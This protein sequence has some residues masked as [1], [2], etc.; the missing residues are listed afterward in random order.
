MLTPHDSSPGTPAEPGRSPTEALLREACDEIEQRIR[1]GEA[2]RAEEYLAR[3]PSLADDPEQ[4]L[5]LIYVEYAA[6]RDR[7][8]MQSREEYFARFPH[9]QLQLQRQFHLDELLDDPTPLQEE[10]DAESDKSYS[11]QAGPSGGRFRILRL[12]AR[13]GIGQVMRAVDTELNRE[14]A[15]KELQPALADSDEVRERF[16]REA[17]ITGKLEHPGIVPVYGLGRD[18]AG[19]P[20]YAMRLV[21]GQSFQQAVQTFHQGG[22]KLDRF[23]GVEFQKLL[24]RFLHVCETVAFAHSRGIIH[25]DLKPANILLGPFGETLVVDWGLARATGP[26][27]PQNAKPDVAAAATDK[28][29]LSQSTEPLSTPV[30]HWSNELTQVS[31]ELIGTP[32]FM[33]PEQ[34]SG[35]ARG[36][37]PAGDVY[38]LG[39]TLYMLLTGR[40]PFVGSD[41]GETLVRVSTGTF[42]RPRE[43]SRAI[44]RALEAVCLKAMARRPADRY[45]SPRALADDLEHWLADEP[46]TAASDPPVA[47]LARWGRRHRT[48]VVAGSLALVLV[49]VVAVASAIRI[50][51][52]RMRADRER[53]EANR[54][55]SRL[56]FDRGFALTENHEYGA[57]MLWF[58]RSL[59]H[60]PRS[61]AAM[62][63]V[64]LTNLDAA[65]PHLVRRQRVFTHATPLAA[66]AFSEDGQRLLTTEGGGKGHLW[67]PEAGTELI[68]HHLP[69]GRIIAAEI[70]SDGAAL[71]AIQANREISVQRLPAGVAEEVDPPVVIAHA[72]EIAFAAISPSGQVLSASG[73]S[74]RSPKVRFWRVADGEQLAEFDHPRGVSQIVFQP[75][76]NS[77]ATVSDDGQARLWDLNDKR[78]IREFRPATGRIKRIAFTPDGQ[79]L[80]AGDTTGSISCWDANDGRRLFDVARHSGTVT[81]VACAADGQTVAGAWDTGTIRTWDLQTRRPASELLRLDRWTSSLAFRPGTRQLLVAA[82]RTALVLWNLPDPTG[83]APPLNQSLVGAAAFSADGKIAATGSVDGTARLRDGGTGKSF[84]KTLQHKSAVKQVAFRPDGAVV[85]TASDDGT[86]RLWSTAGGRPHGVPLDHRRNSRGAILVAAA[87]FSPDGSLIVTGDNAGVIRTWNGDT[88]ELIRVV[89]DIQGTTTSVCFSPAGDRI[90]AG[91]G[92]PENGVRLWKTEG[93]ELRWK[94][95]H[96]GPVRSVAISSN[97]RVVISGSNDDTAR[98]WAAE[99]GQP[100]GREL[101]HRGEVFTASFSPDGQLA[102][103]GGYD[104][105]VRL[106]EVPSGQPIGEPMQHEG[107]VMAAAFSADG[108]R[109]LTGSADRSARLWDVITCLPLSPPLLHSDP[110]SAVA[111]NPAGD[112]AVTGRLWHLPAPLADDPPLVERWVRLATERSF[113]AGENIEWLDPKAVSEL[114]REFESRAGQSWSAWGD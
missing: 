53:I 13:G 92:V 113:A 64:I 87:A 54:R 25:R 60:A 23:S 43:L 63:R 45:A 82:E 114:A 94:G 39:A 35:A 19:R 90:V 34:A 52:E 76:A 48:H 55:N 62:R 56:A 33:S 40:A 73:R 58:A 38:S 83:V 71:V 88:G 69:S 27:G 103:T 51:S 102:V 17:E 105:T 80:L 110:V 21:R 14:V 18:S 86:A 95:P 36:V 68:E 28:L 77:V 61:D 46:V 22:N 1:S 9:W 106:W 75:R 32:A 15:V 79:R 74:A 8:E 84:G 99:S 24:R 10:L 65:Q 66:S 91:F 111:M 78:M 59:E 89:D 42:T 5:D 109:L 98:F 12:L 11:G 26:D 85:L 72:D 57:A 93:G 81:A 47:R 2:A 30:A 97:G 107:I 44:P 6:R 7:G 4:A 112:T 41:V 67:D 3:H 31:G 37:G 29:A 96:G 16:L 100:L 108:R 70:A 104:A 49:T 50:N 20:F 101:V